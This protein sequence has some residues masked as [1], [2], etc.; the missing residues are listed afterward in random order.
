MQAKNK[1]NQTNKITPPTSRREL[2]FSWRYPNSGEINQ[3][4]ARNQPNKQINKE[5]MEKGWEGGKK[6]AEF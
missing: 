1:T 6:K 3:S 5:V 2:L 4:K